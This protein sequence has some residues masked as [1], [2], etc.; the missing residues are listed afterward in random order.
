MAEYEK[1]A[2]AWHARLVRA[3]L[4]G[5]PARYVRAGH[6]LTVEVRNPGGRFLPDVQI[7]LVFD[8]E[9]SKGWSTR[10]S[11]LSIQPAHASSENQGRSRPTAHGCRRRLTACH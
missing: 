9:A 5:L 4:K 2:D 1:E 6:G 3:A 11:G 7:E 8:F 10:H